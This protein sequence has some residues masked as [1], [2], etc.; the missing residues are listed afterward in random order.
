MERLAH[1]FHNLKL[2]PTAPAILPMLLELLHNPNADLDRIAKLVELEPA[3]ALRVLRMCNSACFA[4]LGTTASIPEA[5]TRLGFEDIYILVVAAAGK[6]VLAVA[7][8]EAN[9]EVYNL[10]KHSVVTSL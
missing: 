6:S 7:G 8:P 2:L 4:H 10:W 3:M 1:V 9:Y 5:I